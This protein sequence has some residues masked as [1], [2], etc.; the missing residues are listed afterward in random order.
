[1]TS[2]RR[3]FAARRLKRSDIWSRRTVGVCRKMIDEHHREQRS[4]EKETEEDNRRADHAHPVHRWIVTAIIDRECV[5]LARKIICAI[6][7]F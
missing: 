2:P 6:A 7:A 5:M 3:R 4:E 1:M